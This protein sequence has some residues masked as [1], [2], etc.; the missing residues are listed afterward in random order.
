MVDVSARSGL[1]EWYCNITLGG[2]PFGGS[3][4]PGVKVGCHSVTVRR[5]SETGGPLNGPARLAQ[6][7]PRGPNFLTRKSSNRV[8]IPEK[9]LLSEALPRI[10]PRT[11]HASAARC[12]R[13]WQCALSS[14]EEHFLHTEGVACSNHAARTILFSKDLRR[15]DLSEVMLVAVTPYSASSYCLGPG[16]RGD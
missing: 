5:Q 13:T 4:F 14:A 6:A 10:C 11:T 8:R 1:R 12:L 16:F 2:G 3:D 7:R 15:F 9:C